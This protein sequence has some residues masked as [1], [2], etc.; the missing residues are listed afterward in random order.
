MDYANNGGTAYFVPAGRDEN[1]RGFVGFLTLASDPESAY[2]RVYSSRGAIHIE[3]Q[4]SSKASGGYVRPP[5]ITGNLIGTLVVPLSDV[6]DSL[7]ADGLVGVIRD[8]KLGHRMSTVEDHAR[9]LF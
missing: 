5:E 1:V 8:R 9:F 7:P 6:K 4:G 2:N 3:L